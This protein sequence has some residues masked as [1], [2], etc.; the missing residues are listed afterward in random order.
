MGVRSS[1]YADEM[2]LGIEVI[3]GDAGKKWPCS[4]VRKEKIERESPFL[5][6]EEATPEQR[7]GTRLHRWLGLFHLCE[8]RREVKTTFRQDGG[9][10]D[11][12]YLTEVLDW[13]RAPHHTGQIRIEH[14][15]Y[16]IYYAYPNLLT[17][18]SLG[19]RNKGYFLLRHH[20]LRKSALA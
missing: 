3:K 13:R 12:A 4:N 9:E 19:H 10:K 20:I 11:L 17:P 14:I 7:E 15:W 8:E 1:G 6:K 5:N 16:S 2:I 18:H